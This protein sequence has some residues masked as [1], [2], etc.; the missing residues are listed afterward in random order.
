[1][2]IAAAGATS[3]AGAAGD[4][5]LA[6]AKDLYLSAAYKDALM[7]LSNVKA[8]VSAS[9]AIEAAEYRVFCLL[10]LNRRAEADAA[11]QGMVEADPFYQPSEAQVSP[12][13]RAVFRDVRRSVLPPSRSARTPT[14]R[15]RSTART[16][17]RPRN[18]P[19]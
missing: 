17:K 9:E 1:M 13:I 6:R 15:A 7:V 10:A 11:I 19:G 4:A 12:R 18:S 8:D 3:A 16:R 14:P 5:A 2:I